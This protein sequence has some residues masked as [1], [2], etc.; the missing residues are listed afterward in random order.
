M[1][2]TELYEFWK[3]EGADLEKERKNLSQKRVEAIFDKS[4]KVEIGDKLEEFLSI[5]S[6]NLTLSI[7][8]YIEESKKGKVNDERMISLLGMINFERRKFLKSLKNVESKF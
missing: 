1:S 3:V 2:D 8:Q 4:E 7:R 5:H 6:M